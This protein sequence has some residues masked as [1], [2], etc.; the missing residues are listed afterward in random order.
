MQSDL[1][2]CD[3]D[4]IRHL[5]N[6]PLYS[7]HN[8]P[9]VMMISPDTATTKQRQTSLRSLSQ[10]KKPT[11][12]SISA[13]ESTQADKSN[14]SDTIN[15]NTVLLSDTA[16]GEPVVEE[17]DSN[18]MSAD[19]LSKGSRI[20]DF[21]F[22]DQSIEGRRLYRDCSYLHSFKVRGPHYLTDKKK[23]KLQYVY[24]YICDRQGINMSKDVFIL[25]QFNPS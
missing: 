13:N 25:P 19:G 14:R 1:S 22:L 16:G 18:V 8:I 21:V 6:M 23:V 9:A 17:E 5:L 7:P 24:I 3:E 4:S 10:Q 15:K 12:N 2:L 20:N 11:P